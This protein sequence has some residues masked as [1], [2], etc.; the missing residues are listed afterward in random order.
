MSKSEVAKDVKTSYFGGDAPSV[1]I[2][3]PT[4]NREDVLLATLDQ[5]LSQD[6][7]ADEIIVVDQSETHEDSTMRRLENLVRE[8]RIRWLVSHPANLPAARNRA[9]AETVCDIVVFIDDDVRL[10]S[11]FLWQHLKNYRDNTIHSVAGRI[12]QPA[13][14]RYPKRKTAWPKMLDYLYFPLNATQ[15]HTGIATFGGGNHSIRTDFI[16]TLGGYDENYLGYAFREDSDAAMRIWKAGGVI[17]FD[18]LASLEHLAAP[19]G[20]CRVNSSTHETPEWSV[21][22]PAHYFAWRH[23]FPLPSFWYQTLIHN[24]RKYVL[25]RRNL[26]HPWRVPWSLV[27]YVYSLAGSGLASRG[28]RKVPG[29]CP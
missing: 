29:T 21:S 11:D 1:C 5:V 2:A 9:L 23:F 22:W 27:S 28:V 24:P 14:Y 12:I 3:I 13:G 25:T 8:G 20:G 6:I 18:P 7:P 19:S 10:P 26:R 15:R 16:R 17:L 4:F